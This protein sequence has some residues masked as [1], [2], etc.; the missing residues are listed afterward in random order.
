M[1]ETPQISRASKIE[2]AKRLKAIKDIAVSADDYEAI[3]Q[4]IV[5]TDEVEA[6][7][8]AIK[9]LSEEDEF[10]LMCRLMGTA[11]HMVRLEQNPIIRGDYIVADFWAR[12]QPGCYPKQKRAHESLGFR[13][14]VE[15]KSTEKEKFKIG[16]SDLRRRRHF[17]QE[18]GLP[19]LI[20]VRF[21][22][23]G[24]S[25][26]WAIV[27]DADLQST[28]LTIT[29]ADL[30]RGVRHI[31]W[32]EYFYMMKP[33]LL[34]RTVYDP[35][36]EE[37]GAYHDDYGNLKE[38]HIVDG[39]DVTELTGHEALIINSFCKGFSLTPVAHEQ[40]GAATIRTSVPRLTF[41]SIADMLY[42][43]NRLPTDGSG[44]TVYDASKI[45][46]RADQDE[47]GEL[48]TRQILDRIAAWMFHK[49]LAFVITMGEPDAQFAKWQEYGGQ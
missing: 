21:L 26:M 37:I 45:V 17:A 15:V 49:E 38:F 39:N 20:A 35:A 14:L 12:F 25:A 13:C 11:T 9:G 8:E 43:F 32:D 16:G 10:A 1:G 22:R 36:A 7:E 40:Q 33:G 48:V 24:Q 27:E 18:F 23:Y 4:R 5:A 28:S 42:K 46:A 6:V 44:Q 31:I 19:L 34:F 2:T 30:I 47:P 29:A 41:C 3:R